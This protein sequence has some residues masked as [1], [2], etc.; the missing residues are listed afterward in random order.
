MVQEGWCEERAKTVSREVVKALGEVEGFLLDHL[1]DPRTGQYFA[2]YNPRVI[3]IEEY[4]GAGV[5]M[6][7]LDTGMLSNHPRLRGRIVDSVDLTGT[8]EGPEDLHGHGTTVALIALMIAPEVNILN[9]KVL[10]RTKYGE[11][12]NLISGLRWAES[13]GPRVIN[14]SLGIERDDPDGTCRTCTEVRRI[15]TESDILVVAAAGNTPGVQ[16]C[17][18]QGGDAVVVGA[19]DYDGVRLA[20][21][22]STGDFYATGAFNVVPIDEEGHRID[23]PR[24]PPP[25]WRRL[26]RS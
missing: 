6:A 11:E 15:Q 2:P 24:E 4:T 19:L 9:V 17:P 1:F 7:I 10:D 23:V 13:R 12:E 16:V 5:T 26:F 21:Y 3:G 8:G 14:L 22:S 20:D 18:V 25:W